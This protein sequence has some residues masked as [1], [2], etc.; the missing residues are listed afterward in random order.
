MI[1]D[2]DTSLG[3]LLGMCCD[4]LDFNEL[5][6]IT[7]KGNADKSARWSMVAKH[8]DNDLPGGN[9]IVPVAARDVHGRFDDV[10]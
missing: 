8:S 6:W 2:R 5:I 10:G 9:Q 7:E 1:D 3:L 4:H